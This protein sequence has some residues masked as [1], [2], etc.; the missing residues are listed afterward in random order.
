MSKRADNK[1]VNHNMA[2]SV[3]T[4]FGVEGFRYQVSEKMVQRFRVDVFKPLTARTFQPL[5][6]EPR[7]LNLRPLKPE[8]LLL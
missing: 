3:Y 5:N 1:D 2:L 6:S 8:T 4:Y 7:T